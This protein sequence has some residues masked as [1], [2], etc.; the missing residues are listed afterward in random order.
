M[1]FAD[2]APT[3]PPVR[4]LGDRKALPARLAEDLRERLASEEW[5][6]GERIPTEAEL[7][8]AYRVSRATVRQALKTLEAQG[9]IITMRGRGSFVAGGALIRAGMQELK[10]ITSTIAEMG[11]TPAM[12]YHHRVLRPAADAESGMFEVPAGSEVLDI[13]RRIL[14]D[15]IVVAYSYD[16]L[17]RWVFP[18]DFVPAQL[19][20][21]VFAFLAQTN[22]PVPIRAVAQVHAVDSPD[23]AWGDDDL[24]E[25][26]L[27]VLLDQLHYDTGNRPFMH[28]RSYF[29]EGR[30]NFTVLRTSPDR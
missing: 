21:S 9:L 27:F 15:G 17:P 2:V 16:V 29:V 30:F 12:L 6:P 3:E 5:Q 23:V 26:Q 28:T 10:S 18:A 22:G 11:H 20:G 14:A 13:Q 24:G 1:T 8:E 25:H 7:V 19:T 4:P